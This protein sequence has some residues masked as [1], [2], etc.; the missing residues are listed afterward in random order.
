MGIGAGLIYLGYWCKFKNGREQMADCF[1]TRQ[2]RRETMES[3]P[4]DMEFLKARV[5]ALADH[6]GMPEDDIDV[7]D[8]AAASEM[9]AKADSAASS[10]RP[11]TEEDE[12]ISN[13]IQT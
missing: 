10:A 2:R 1:R 11:S 6:T 8:T 9:N 7:E 4:E 13:E 5:A 12:E 3:L